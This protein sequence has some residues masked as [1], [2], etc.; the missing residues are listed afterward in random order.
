M[1]DMKI[2][3][4]AGERGR[5]GGGMGEGGRE[6]G[7]KAE[8]VKNAA[9]SRLSVRRSDDTYEIGMSHDV[10]YGYYLSLTHVHARPLG[11][12]SHAS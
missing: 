11:T 10:K 4:G 2:C 7:S 3:K 6:G 8:P 12:R 5:V 1:G 9:A